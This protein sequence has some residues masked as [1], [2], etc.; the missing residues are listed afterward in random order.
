[1]TP[2]APADSLRFEDRDGSVPPQYHSDTISTLAADGTG[3]RR[4]ERA[5]GKGPV[6]ET[7]LALAPDAL[8][9]LWVDLRA[10]GLFSTDWTKDPMPCV[11]GGWWRLT[12]SHRGETATLRTPVVREQYEASR[13]IGTRVREA[14]KVARTS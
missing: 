6:T 8:A 7:P 13:A 11:G 2:D 10:L 4:V 3:R 9:A 5:Y 12:V 14:L 1:M